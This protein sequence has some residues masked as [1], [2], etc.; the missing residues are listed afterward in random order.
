[1]FK[2]SKTR[3]LIMDQIKDVENTLVAFKSFLKAATVPTTSIETL[4]ALLKGVNDG[5]DAADAS[6]RAMIDSLN[7]GAYLPSTRENIISIATSCDKIANKCESTATMIVLYR[8]TFPAE[9]AEDIDKIYEV[10]AEQFSLLQES[11]D[12]LFSKMNVLQKDPAILDKIR[13]LESVI[14]KIELKLG[15]II[16]GSDMELAAKMQTFG[17]VERICDISDIIEDI[18]DKIQIIL[19]ARKA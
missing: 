18:A 5:E 10:T 8:F 17:L 4:K 14:D 7:C 16:F 3:D 6:L 19:I 2:K 1:M 12:M 9:F 11:I 13:S 15:D